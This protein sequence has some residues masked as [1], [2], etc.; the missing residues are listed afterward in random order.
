MFSEVLRNVC[1]PARCKNKIQEIDVAV[2]L[3]HDIVQN[4]GC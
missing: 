4:L 1:E 3:H 2:L